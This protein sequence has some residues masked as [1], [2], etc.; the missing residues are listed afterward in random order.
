MPCNLVTFLGFSSLL[1]W[2][3]ASNYLLLARDAAVYNGSAAACAVFAIVLLLCGLLNGLLG[4]EPRRG[5]LL[6]TALAAGACGIGYAAGGSDGVR[7]LFFCLQM[8]CGAVLVVSWGERLA[9][10]GYRALVPL[11]CAAGLCSAAVLLACSLA[12]S[13]AAMLPAVV[14]LPACSGT[15]LFVTLEDS[16]AGAAKDI[17]G[18]T[19][20][21]AGSGFLTFEPIDPAS[22]R[23]LP[24]MLVAVLCLCTFVAS[25]FGG[26]ATNPY[27]TNSGTVTSSMLA[28]TA[29]EL[30]LMGTGSLR[31]FSAGRTGNAG[32]NGAGRGVEDPEGRPEG[33]GVH[34]ARRGAGGG[35]GCA[36]DPLPLMQLMA[37]LALILLV[38]GLL[39]FSMKLP[40]TMTTALGMV[41]GAKNCLVVLCWIVFAREIAD[42]RLPFI[43]CFALLVLA[44]G[45]LYVPYLGAWV[46]KSRGVGFEALTSTATA[47]IAFVAVLAILYMVARMRQMGA[48]QRALQEAAPPEPLSLEDIRKALRAHRLALME[49]YGLTER[50]QQIVTMI[51]DGQTLGGIAEELFIT[52]RTVKFHSKNAYDKLGVHNKKELMQMFSER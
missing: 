15:C 39:L 30:A 46:N 37:G 22:L 47:I 38:G 40:G 51:V 34:A 35:G 52:E 42:A 5:L 12:G 36:R 33:M 19:E 3:Q 48:G 49:P 9:L 43:P 25:L 6:G 28:L 32:D 18:R 20:H 11:A 24:W 50:E 10:F 17:R 27:L 7:L 23:Q 13:T 14:A 26:M 16:A 44:S 31:Y 45:A 29:V 2:L 4:V 21:T 8:G 1:A 41:L